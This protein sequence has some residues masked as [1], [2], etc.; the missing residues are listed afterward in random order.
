[1]WSVDGVNKGGQRFLDF[2]GYQPIHDRRL[3]RRMLGFAPKGETR[4]SQYQAADLLRH[5]TSQLYRH[6]CAAGMPQHMDRSVAA[7]FINEGNEILCVLRNVERRVFL[8]EGIRPV[9]S[10]AGRYRA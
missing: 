1:A 5:A 9:A 8:F 7:D 2:S 6:L 3:K 4:V 10:Q